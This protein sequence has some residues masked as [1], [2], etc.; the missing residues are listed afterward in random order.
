MVD[1][2]N[3]MHESKQLPLYIHLDFRAQGE[4]V[5]SFLNSD[6]G[7]D[8]LDNSQTSGIDLFALGSIELGLYLL[9]QVGPLF[10]FPF[11]GSYNA[12]T[13]SVTRLHR[14]PAIWRPDPYQ[15]WSSLA[16][17]C[18]WSRAGVT[19]EQTM[20]FQ[21]TPRCVRRRWRVGP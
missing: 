4:V 13:Q 9:D 7:E 11:S 15:N 14:L 20:T 5:Q 10:C 18:A 12:S 17:R 6:I 8:R 3:I 2:T 16:P 1:F 19:S 21:N